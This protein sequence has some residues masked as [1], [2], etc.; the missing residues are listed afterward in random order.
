LLPGVKP[1]DLTVTATGSIIT[2]RATIGYDEKQ[3]KQEKQEKEAKA[4][5]SKKPDAFVQRE[6][7]TGGMLRVIDLPE[8]INAEKRKSRRPTSMAY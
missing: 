1:E 7:Y 2:I 6:R 8:P 3:E 5:D 4:T